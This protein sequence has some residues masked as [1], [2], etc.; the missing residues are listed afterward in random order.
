MA[1]IGG[2]F[3]PQGNQL[4]ISS[5]GAPSNF[6]AGAS[7]QA[8]DYDKIM[9]QYGNFVGNVSSN[10]VTP[11]TVAPQTVAPTTSPY[12][13]SAD[14]TGSLANLSNL[15]QTGGY[16]PQGIADIRARDIS[17]TRGIYANAQQNVERQRALGG[18]YS[19]N[20]NASQAQ[21]ARDESNQV[22]GIDTAANAG[23]AQNVAANEISASGTYAGAAASANA[24]RQ[25]AN[26]ANANIVNQIN[27][28]NA[29][30]NLSGQQGNQAAN[31]NAQF[32]NR[33]NILSGLEGSKNLY[34]TT[35]ALTQTFGNQVMQAGQLGQGQQKINEQQMRDIYGAAS[36]G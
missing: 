20:F 12:Q 22:A 2:S 36:G 28:S 34:G 13:Q 17:P 23:I 25:G 11:T 4:P 6:A 5:F 8:S 30:R 35:P 14:V 33:A 31:L 21:M 3:A 16:T 19:P 24:E 7:Q 27:E 26:L 32:G 1:G 15:S 9:Q 10:P 18:G 29:N